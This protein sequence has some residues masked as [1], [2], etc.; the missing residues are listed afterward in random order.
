MELHFSTALPTTTS[1]RYTFSVLKYFPSKPNQVSIISQP[2]PGF[3]NS[4]LRPCARRL[5]KSSP[6]QPEEEDSSIKSD[7]KKDKPFQWRST[8]LGETS[9]ATDSAKSKKKFLDTSYFGEE[10]TDNMDWCVRA[11]KLALKTIEER[12]FAHKLRKMVTPKKKRKKRKSGKGKLGKL[13]LGSIDHILDNLG[14]KNKLEE[15]DRETVNLFTLDMD[16]GV[17]VGGKTSLKNDQSALTGK[18]GQFA[19]GIFEE[20]RA[21]AKAAF[22]DRLSQF[23]GP[24]NHKMEVTL[25]KQIVNACTAEEVLDVIS[26]TVMAVAKGLSPS[27]LSPLNIATAL[28]RIAKNMEKVQMI[29]TRRLGFMR[30]KEMSLLVGIAMTALPNCNAQGLS[31]ITWAL[32]KIGGDLLFQ[33][34]MDRI[35]SIAITKVDDFNAQNVAN[36][37][38]A[39]ATMRHAAPDLFT[40]L[41]SRAIELV[42]TFKELE[43]TQFLWA[44]ATLNAHIDPFLDALDNVFH[45]QVG[46][47]SENETEDEIENAM[48]FESLEDLEDLDDIEDKTENEIS[49]ESWKDREDLDEIEHEFENEIDSLENIED[50]DVLDDIWEN[51]TSS[52]ESHETCALNFTRDQIASISWSYA[53]LGQTGRPFFSSIWSILTQLVTKRVSDQFREDVL[54]ASQIYVANQC[55]K[56]ENPNSG[57]ALKGDLEKKIYRVG[58]TKRFNIKTTSL[59]QKEVARLLVATG[60]NWVREYPIDGYTVDAVLVDEKVAFEIDGPSHFSRNL[61]TP[62]GHTMMKRRY[63]A[64]A[65]WKLVTL[66]HYEWEALSGEFKQLEYLRK[67]IGNNEDT[68]SV[69]VTENEQ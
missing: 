26:D 17:E 10:E 42:E 65:G 21:N 48:S 63:I 35:A 5:R 1:P 38:L 19:D 23:S 34:E 6:V 29:E 4:R 7:K 27:P 50:L 61:G 15:E 69:Y 46:L 52:Y 36:V 28:H 54:F 66:S 56:V 41:A 24:S 25:N 39:Y 44:C 14:S 59:F 33:S 12:G 47:L 62:L 64:A 40:K 22:V 57:L 3:L 13:S 16:S 51:V 53:V 18:I 30:Q 32:S 45:K 43:M 31:N 8:F 2:R 11:R 68:S 37:A 55:L 49:S 58:Q 67:I 60:S 20:K 9:I